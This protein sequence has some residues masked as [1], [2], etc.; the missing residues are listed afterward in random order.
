MIMNRAFRRYGKVAPSRLVHFCPLPSSM[1]EY[2][3]VVPKYSAGLFS[4]I[5]ISVN[6]HFSSIREAASP[7]GPAPM[8]TAD[9]SLVDAGEAEGSSAT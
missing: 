2:A 9:F 3:K 8:I 1:Y 4:M 6:P 5:V 7:T